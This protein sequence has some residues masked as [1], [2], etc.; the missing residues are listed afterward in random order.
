[1]TEFEFRKVFADNVR[2][3]LEERQMTQ[4][5]LTKKAEVGEKTLAACLGLDKT[6]SINMILKLCDAFGCTIDRLVV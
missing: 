3:L 1:M 5:E 4:R 2:D 6:P